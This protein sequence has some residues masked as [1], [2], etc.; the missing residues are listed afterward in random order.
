MNDGAVPLMSGY[1]ATLWEDGRR[2]GWAIAMVIARKACGE[3]RECRAHART[4][5]SAVKSFIDL[6]RA[7][8]RE[9]EEKR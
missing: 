1:S 6:A 8:A 5:P 7:R 4:Y 9:R 2:R 3:Q